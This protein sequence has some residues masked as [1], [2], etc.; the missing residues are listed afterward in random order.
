MSNVGSSARWLACTLLGAAIAAACARC[1]GGAPPAGPP[2]DASPDGV[3]DVADSAASTLEVSVDAGP[4]DCAPSPWPGY[5]ALTLPGACCSASLANNPASMVAPLTWSPCDAGAGC[6]QF[7]VPGMQNVA[8]TVTRGADGW[9]EAIA[10]GAYLSVDKTS[11]EQRVYDIHLGKPLLSVR[12][13]VSGSEGCLASIAGG[14]GRTFSM[15]ALPGLQLFATSFFPLAYDGALP[16]FHYVAKRGDDL[17]A[18]NGIQE[19]YSTD[20]IFAYDREPGG[21]IGR[22]SSGGG[23]SETSIKGVPML[24][25][26][27]E[28]DDVF[29]ISQD[30][31]SLGLDQFYVWPEGAAGLQLLIDNPRHIRTMGSDGATLFWVECDPLLADGGLGSCDAYAA[32]YTT[33]PAALAASRR[34]L[35]PLPEGGAGSALGFNGLFAVTL[36]D[37]GVRTYRAS[38]GATVKIASSDSLLRF[39]FSI[40][41]SE[42]VVEVKDA[43]TNQHLRLEK[44]PLAWP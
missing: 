24:L 22:W 11:Y 33:S 36:V 40:T 28:R 21:Q 30:G 8:A 35:G 32:P 14:N 20:T 29:A 18:S 3:S 12:S 19:T 42:I 31:S 16:P 34:W 44:W 27:A 1:S 6:Q 5:T 17:H 10:I 9:P 2:L 13:D 41:S 25:Q 7:V 15:Y 4:L 39:P 38:D 37:G 43:K 23:T 26:F